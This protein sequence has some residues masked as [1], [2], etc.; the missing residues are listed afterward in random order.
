MSLENVQYEYKSTDTD[1]KVRAEWT[2]Q[3]PRFGKYD[4]AGSE[5]GVHV[6][7]GRLFS[8]TCHLEA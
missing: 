4:G 3:R 2:F 5:S 6:E 1:A 7:A 8:G